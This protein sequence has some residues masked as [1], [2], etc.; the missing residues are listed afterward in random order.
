MLDKNSEKILKLIISE[1][2]SGKEKVLFYPE[3]LCRYDIDIPVDMVRDVL[4][5]LDDNDYIRHLDTIDP[6][7]IALLRSK[8]LTYFEMKNKEFIRSI[9]TPVTVSVIANL[10]IAAL[11]WLWPLLMQWLASFLL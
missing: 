3:D 1:S 8:G 6:A 5:K 7:G 4:K 2:D 11:K 10:I 9:V